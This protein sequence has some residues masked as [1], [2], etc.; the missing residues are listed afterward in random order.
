MSDQILGEY[1]RKMIIT[2][3]E[4]F[5]QQQPTEYVHAVEVPAG[6][7]KIKKYLATELIREINEGSVVGLG[8]MRSFVAK[9]LPD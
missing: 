2:Y 7:N 1:V 9:R 6:S 4:E 3:L 8:Y 5:S